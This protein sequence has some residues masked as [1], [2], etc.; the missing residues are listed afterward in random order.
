MLEDFEGYNIDYAYPASVTQLSALVKASPTNPSEKALFYSMGSSGTSNVYIKINTALPTGKVL[1]DFDSLLFNRYLSNVS[2][3]QFAIWINGTRVHQ[4][5]IHGS[6]LDQGVVKIALSAFNQA[7]AAAA[8]AS[9]GNNPE[10]GIGIT[11]WHN[12][13]SFYVDNVKLS[14]GNQDNGGGD[15][16]GNGGTGGGTEN[17]MLNNFN[18]SA[19]GQTY[20]MRAWN[21]GDGTATV[22]ADPVN[23]TNQVVNVVTSNWDAILLLTVTMPAGQTLGDYTGFS[24]DMYIPT[25]AGDAN[26]NYKNMFI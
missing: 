13:T 10:I 24:F 12:N 25:N 16:G 5:Q 26:P 15:N 23:P 11:D 20:S 14:G 8:V 9:A 21:T 19:I 4:V 6:N 7:G 2:Y 17:L 22:V 3:K 18:A 1:A